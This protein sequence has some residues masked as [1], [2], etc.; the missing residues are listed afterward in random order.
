MRGVV[1]FLGG[2]RGL[3]LT[4]PPE[5]EYV[6]HDPEENQRAGPHDRVPVDVTVKKFA[7]PGDDDVGGRDSNEAGKNR[8]HEHL[9]E[10]QAD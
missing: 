8:P 6:K 5:V 3:E 7:D 4:H 10:R 9:A 2:R 1:L